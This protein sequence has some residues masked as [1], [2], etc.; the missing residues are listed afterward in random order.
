MSISIGPGTVVTFDAENESNAV[1]I[2][3]TTGNLFQAANTEVILANGAHAK[4]IFWQVAGKVLVGVSAKLAGVL[5]VKTDVTFMTS[6]SRNGRIFVVI[7]QD[8]KMTNIGMTAHKIDR[9][10]SDRTI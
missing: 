2:L 3:Q 9:L 10:F 8:K 4:S 5:L 7:H 1:F 6:S